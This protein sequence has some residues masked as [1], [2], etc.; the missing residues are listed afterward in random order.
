MHGL[1]DRWA[2]LLNWSTISSDSECAP[3]HTSFL[4]MILTS[5]V[6]TVLNSRI[7]T[8]GRFPATYT[9]LIRVSLLFKSRP[10]LES[11]FLN[12]LSALSWQDAW[13]LSTNGCTRPSRLWLA[14]LGYVLQW[15][16]PH[17]RVL[18]IA[19][20]FWWKLWWT[21][22]LGGTPPLNFAKTELKIVFQI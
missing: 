10:S 2:S 17:Y 12:Q 5:L 7:C 13:V 9:C 1:N 19:A 18:H 3:S 8:V 14:Q 21:H 15:H 6:W 11:P 20:A 22:R 16:S 4:N